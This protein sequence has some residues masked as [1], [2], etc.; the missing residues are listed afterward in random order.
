MRLTGTGMVFTPISEHEILIMGGV[1][2][3]KN[4]FILDMDIDNSIKKVATSQYD[5]FSCAN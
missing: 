2:N 1:K 3:R 5:F 4:I